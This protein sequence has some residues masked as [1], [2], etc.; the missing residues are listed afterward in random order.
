MYFGSGYKLH[1]TAMTLLILMDL[2]GITALVYAIKEQSVYIAMV[3]GFVITCLDGLFQ[4]LYYTVMCCRFISNMPFARSRRDHQ[5]DGAVLLEI[6]LYTKI[7]DTEAQQPH[8][9]L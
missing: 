8:D 7:E 9:R 1:D 6:D 5:P 4:I 2:S 3:I